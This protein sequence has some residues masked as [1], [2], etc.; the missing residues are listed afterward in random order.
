M[1]PATASIRGMRRFGDAWFA[2]I[3]LL[4]SACHDSSWEADEELAQL[5]AVDDDDPSGRLGGGPAT[6]AAAAPPASAAR[7]LQSSP[8]SPGST[9]FAVLPDTQYYALGY[10]GLLD[11]QAWWISQKAEELGIAYVFHLGDIVH[12]NTDLEW[13]RASAAMSLLDGVVP[14]ALVPGNHDYGPSGAAT[15]R[16]SGLNAWFSFADAAAAPSFGGAF[17]MGKLDNTYRVFEAGGHAW[18]A[19]LLEWGPRD[20]VVAW[21]DAVMTAHPDR[22]GI[23]V[24]HAYLDNNDLRQ[25][26]TD[27]LH[28]QKHNP[29]DY[30]TPGS[31]NDGEELWQKLVRRHRFVM[32]LSGHIL[33]DGAGYLASVDDHG[34]VVHQM[35]ANYQMRAIGGEGYLRLLELMPDGRT[36]HVRTYSPLLDRYLVDADQQFTIELDVD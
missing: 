15:S 18:I 35:L 20:E 29:H 32:T 34:R 23:L 36:V 17:E 24:T 5:E 9:V 7:S 30:A 26:H 2:G 10:P 4:A 13:E 28:P 25:D 11:M 3:G 12:N 19:L 27:E 1:M 21:A 33:G 31:V 6:L 22:L 8:F 14:Y 16:D